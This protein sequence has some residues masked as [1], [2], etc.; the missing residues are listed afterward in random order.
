[1][2]PF[3]RPSPRTFSPPSGRRVGARGFTLIELTIVLLIVGILASTA[4]YIFGI[5]VNK[6]R[7]TQAQV[8][9]K[10]L[11]KTQTMYYGDAGRYTDN[12]AILDYDPVKYPYYNVTVTV[13]DNTSG[14][15]QD[16]LG[17]ATG[18]G[19]MAGDVWWITRE[20]VPVHAQDNAVINR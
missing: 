19:P 4:V 9:L 18:T 20:G 5:M 16:F 14:P 2:N 17:V 8:V 12:T 3:R 1:M 6:A 10:H 11:Y 13:V 7:M 15:G